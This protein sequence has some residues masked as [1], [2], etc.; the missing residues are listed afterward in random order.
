MAQASQASQATPAAHHQSRSHAPFTLVSPLLRAGLLLG[1]AGGFALAT[2]L[3]LTRALGKETGL[4]WTAVAQA[5][6]HLQLYGWAGLFVLGVAFH[7]VPR[8]RGA[9][10]AWPRLVPVLL[11]CQVASLI[12]RAVSQPLLATSGAGLWRV[13]LILSGVLECI[14]I[15]CAT[16][17]FVAT[18][19]RGTSL[20]QR[21]GV[22]GILPF[23][24]I[25]LVS[26]S[27]ASAVNLVN[28]VR[29]ASAN[30]VVTGPWD[31]LNVTL[32]LLGFLVPMALAMSARSLPMYAG[33]DAFPAR[34]LWPL[35]FVYGAG[36]VF[37]A[38]S[39]FGVDQ[40]Q[41]LAG[42]GFV[43]LGAVLL[44]F[45]GIFM[46]M[47]R[48]RGKLPE[49]VAK[50]SKAPAENARAYRSHVAETR[51]TYGP[52]VALVGSAYMWAVLGGI[53][54]VVFGAYLV[55]GAVPPIPL[56]AA[57]HSLALGFIALL[58]SGIAPR[59]LP[60]FSGKRIRS[61]LLVTA[62]LWLGNGAALLRVGSLLL[63][64]VLAASAP[65]L[66]WVSTGA[67]GLSG[68]V[69]LALACCLAINLWPAL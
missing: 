62:S 27:C 43:I 7:F 49:R 11:A 42:V 2:V 10:L 58:I 54:L 13:L 41:R 59:M 40:A 3:T 39:A 22:W 55:A 47:M 5:H 4:W 18:A 53:L 50:L 69:G 15:G 29:A 37:V 45:V 64:P 46:R 31:D 65:G 35:A 48:S 36:L 52:F 63:L 60:G 33:L 30:G 24:A 25:I 6:G 12:V 19:V 44:A 28:S 68:P 66:T 21:A 17:L 38:S 9:P 23:L 20:R 32:G 34:A 8:L 56:D 1:V 14:A 61:P 67:F 57:R 51:N 16:A 26:L